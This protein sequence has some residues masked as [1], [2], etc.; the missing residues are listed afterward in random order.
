ML[1]DGHVLV[2]HATA[3]D[4]ERVLHCANEMMNS[5]PYVLTAQGEFAMTLEQERA[6]L[7]ASL[8]HQRQLFLIAEVSD[9]PDG[10]VGLCSLTQN[11]AKRKMRHRVMLGMGMRPALRG[12]RVG[13]ALMHEAVAWAVGHPELHMMVLAVYASNEAGLRLYRAHG[14]AEWGRLPDGLVE[15]DG[16]MSEQIEMVRWVKGG[17][18]VSG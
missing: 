1:P 12:R 5:S 8:E 11:T 17:G 3:D 9:A 13:T 6:F 2:R 4:A 10:I 16:T 7:V 15:D 14:F 18:A